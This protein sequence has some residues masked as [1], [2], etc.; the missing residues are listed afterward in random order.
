MAEHLIC[1]LNRWKLIEN[2]SFRPALFVIQQPN[3]KVVSTPSNANEGINELRRLAIN[4]AVVPIRDISN[5]DTQPV[6]ICRRNFDLQL[7]GQP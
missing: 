4:P 2:D 1:M 6:A 7:K 5:D 3:G